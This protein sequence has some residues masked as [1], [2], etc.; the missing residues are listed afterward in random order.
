ML[1]RWW[2]ELRLHVR[3]SGLTVS[4]APVWRRRDAKVRGAFDGGPAVSTVDGL[5][6]GELSDWMVRSAVRGWPIRVHVC[7]LWSRNWAFAVPQGAMAVADVKGA[8][9]MSLERLFDTRADDWHLAV[10]LQ[11]GSR[12]WA[13]AVPRALM[14]ALEVAS[15]A[16]R[17]AIVAVQTD[18]SVCW[19]R[20]CRQVGEGDWL[21]L[22]Q[23]DRV[24]LATTD[25]G[26]LTGWRR[27]PQPAEVLR[28]PGQLRAWLHR[29]AARQGIAMPDRLLTCGPVPDCWRTSGELPR[30]QPLSPMARSPW[31]VEEAT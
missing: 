20:W 3:S 6:W 27:W 17:S 19:N 28:D 30:V 12:A 18:A 29:E 8:A 22:H 5:P 24:A 2:N 11:T 16:N 26:A 9:A 1:E 7:D 13:C 4:G 23:G 31:D 14:A 15:M 25:E 21:L 10:D